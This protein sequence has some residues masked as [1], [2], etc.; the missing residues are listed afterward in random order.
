MKLYISKYPLSRIHSHIEAYYCKFK[1][2]KYYVPN[3]AKKDLFL[4]VV[5]YLDEVWQSILDLTVN[6]FLS[7]ETGRKMKIKIDY[8]DLISLDDTIVMILKPLFVKF[9][10]K[11][12]GYPTIIDENLKYFPVELKT[13]EERYNW[14]LDE[15]IWTFDYLSTDQRYMD[16]H[17]NENF[18]RA[19]RGLLLF[20]LYFNTFWL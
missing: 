16:L 10:E 18:K 2:N 14:L 17:D 8:D 5:R 12:P 13:D 19:N 1:Y 3:D 7:K 20:A 6:K 11:K 4:P 9:K 15:I